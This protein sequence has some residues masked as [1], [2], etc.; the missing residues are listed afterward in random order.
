LPK[1]QL[2]VQTRKDAARPEG[3]VRQEL[4]MKFPE[5]LGLTLDA[6][7]IP[8][9][10]IHNPLT[11]FTAFRGIAPW[12][13]QRQLAQELGI[14]P[15][16]N[17]FFVWAMDGIPFETSFAMPATDATNYLRRIA[18]GLISRLNTRMEAWPVKCEAQWTTNE[19]IIVSGNPFVGPHL[20]AITEPGADF[21]TGGLFPKQE[22][23]APP[24]TGLISEITSRTNL[25]C[26]DWEMTEA[27]VIQWRALSQLSLIMANK[28]I[29]TV[30][31]P[32]QKWIDAVKKKLGNTG[33]L[34]TLTAPDELTALRNSTIGLTG[35][36]LTWLAYWLDAPGFPL[37]ATYVDPAQALSGSTSKVPSQ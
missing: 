13:S 26:Y 15:T 7:Q 18:P 27:R 20:E 33:T 19:Q 10:T 1:M 8:T 23:Q 12:L 24:P 6:W 34:A 37:D 29:T 9:N 4:K 21:L 5:S 3:Y 28:P 32:A 22:H 11:S 16:P 2:T 30:D 36:E 31:T 14:K 35:V 25:V 17:Q